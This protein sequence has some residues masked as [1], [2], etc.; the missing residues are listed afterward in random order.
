[1]ANRIYLVGSSNADTAGPGD[2]GINYDPDTEILAGASRQIP[3]F[4]LSLF[5]ESHIKPHVVQEYRIPAPV[6][7]AAVAR[8]LLQQ[9]RPKILAAF[10]N[11]EPHW[12]A[13]ER[14]IS[15]APFQ[16][17]KLDAT[18]IWDLDPELFQSRLSPAVRWFSSGSAD[19]FAA[20]L[21]IAEIPLIQ[22]RG[23]L[24]RLIAGTTFG[25]DVATRTLTTAKDRA[26]RSDPVD[27]LLHGYAW[28]REVPW[29]EE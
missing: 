23:F 5:D 29:K 15:E 25:Y 8:K 12:G 11:C 19:G 10:S 9:R 13:W 2:E 27:Y 17:F 7:E 16:F 1:M 26:G 3:V 20:L 14:L 24:G 28:V 6:C 4:W 22:P 21:S 18:E